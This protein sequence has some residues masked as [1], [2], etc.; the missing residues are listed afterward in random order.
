LHF[1][2]LS[3]IEAQT[4]RRLCSQTVLLFVGTD[5]AASKRQETMGRILIVDDERAVLATLSEFFSTMRLHADSAG[6]L[7][8]ARSLLLQ[9]DYLAIVT[10]IQLSRIGDTEGLDLLDLVAERSPE[11]PV[12]VLTAYGSHRI[13]REARNRGA[14]FFLYKPVRLDDIGQ[15]VFGLL[16]PK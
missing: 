15:I 8:E 3:G 14:S 13:E 10:D 5:F 7:E 12:V 11:T 16:E 6:S 1:E 9:N 2:T 4:P